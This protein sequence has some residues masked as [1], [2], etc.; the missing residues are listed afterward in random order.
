MVD[1]SLTAHISALR[2]GS[3]DAAGR[4]LPKSR[5]GAAYILG[6]AVLLLPGGLPVVALLCVYRHLRARAA[7]RR[8]PGA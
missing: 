8:R 7:D 6:V 5:R 3:D 2:G 4:M 1:L